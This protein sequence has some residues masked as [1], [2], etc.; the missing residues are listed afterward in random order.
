VRFNV[1]PLVRRRSNRLIATLGKQ[2]DEVFE[3]FLNQRRGPF[4]RKRRSQILQWNR[5]VLYKTELVLA[6]PSGSPDYIHASPGVFSYRSTFQSTQLNSF[7][8]TSVSICRL[9]GMPNL[10]PLNQRQTD[11]RLLDPFS[12]S[13]SPSFPH[14]SRIFTLCTCI[15]STASQTPSARNSSAST[16]PP[17]LSMTSQK[18]ITDVTFSLEPHFQP[19]PINPQ[20]VLKTL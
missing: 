11:V 5:L 15:K 16:P 20:T 9:P 17:N 12:L 14:S 19:N 4:Y 6:F 3:A 10:I 2:P 7:S 8:T 18:C 1:L 13:F